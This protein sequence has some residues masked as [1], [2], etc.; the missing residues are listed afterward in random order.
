MFT[1]D[2][3]RCCLCSTSTS[4]LA[5]LGV[6]SDSAFTVLS[7]H[8]ESVVAILRANRLL[9]RLSFSLHYGALNGV[10]CS[11]VL[12]S[13]ISPLVSFGD[14]VAGTEIFRLTGWH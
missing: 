2:T 13:W 9:H 12:R 1:P 8:P 5:A 3:T 7:E 10:I 4:S 14:V 11:V 6:G